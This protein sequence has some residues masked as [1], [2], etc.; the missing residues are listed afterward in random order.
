[1]AYLAAK[2]YQNDD[3]APYLYKTHDFGRSW[4]KIVG[5][6]RGDDYTHVVREDPTR[7]GLLYAGAEHGAYVSWDDGANWHPL[8]LN[9]P[10]TQI[11]DIVVEQYD[12]VI[13]THGRSMYVLDDVA[14]IRGLN[15]TIASTPIRV[16]PP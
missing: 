1:T 2:N 9:L 13:A 14:P 5:G 10:D 4:T 7:A 11:S 3:R 16:Y 12:L 6:I 8:S 15:P